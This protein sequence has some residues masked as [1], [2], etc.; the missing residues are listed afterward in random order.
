L[1]DTMQLH[2]GK[3]IYTIPGVCLVS[4]ATGINEDSVSVPGKDG[5]TTTHLG[6]KAAEVNVDVQVWTAKQ[7]EVLQKIVQLFRP[8]RGET[9]KALDAI[10]PQL[11][12]YGIKQVYIFNVSAPSYNKSE[13]Y[14]MTLQLREWWPETKTSKKTEKVKAAAA[15]PKA[16]TKNVKASSG[17]DDDGQ[18][19][20]APPPPTKPSTVA[21]KPKG[22]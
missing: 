19:R 3:S 8:K 1:W 13:G 5:V 20:G 9:P 16:N 10:H 22:R 17:S 7:F 21:Q 18:D 12:V 6:Y 14:K 11:E 15:T 4:V 2:S